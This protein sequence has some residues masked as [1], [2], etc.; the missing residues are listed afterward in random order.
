MESIILS[1]I[2]RLKSAVP[3]EFIL[4]ARWIVGIVLGGVRWIVAH[5]VKW[6][7]GDGVRTSLIEI[8]VLD[9]AVR[10]EKVVSRPAFGQRRQRS[11]GELQI[12]VLS[13]AKDHEA[14]VYLLE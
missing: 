2:S 10:I 14:I 4:H 6:D 13:G 7:C 3:V 8:H 5:A 9:E 12:D 1:A 11:V